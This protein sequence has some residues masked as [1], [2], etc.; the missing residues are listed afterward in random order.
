MSERIAILRGMECEAY[1]I[2]YY[3][4]E[5][6]EPACEAAKRALMSLYREQQLPL[7]PEEARRRLLR[8]LVI[9]EAAADAAREEAQSIAY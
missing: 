9:R 1:R 7:L 5:A 6:D 4:L 3:L 2:A 8:R